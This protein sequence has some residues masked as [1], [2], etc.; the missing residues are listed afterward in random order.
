MKAGGWV[1]IMASDEFGT[2]Y[3]GS[4]SNLLLRLQQHKNKTFRGFTSKYNVVKLV[5]YEWHDSLEDMVKRER[6]IKKW[7]RNW[8][9]RMIMDMNPAW[10]DLS[11]D[12]YKAHGY[13]TPDEWE[14]WKKTHTVD[15]GKPHF[16]EDNK[17][18]SPTRACG[19]LGDDEL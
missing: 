15:N 9:L 13:M 6:Q 7:N 18:G 1:Y 8:K 5:Y 11:D 2:I 17:P 12:I 4:T 10:L 14:E 19:A 16:L 3:I